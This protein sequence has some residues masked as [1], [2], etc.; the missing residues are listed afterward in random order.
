MSL[1]ECPRCGR[2]VATNDTSAGAFELPPTLHC[3]HDGE[4]VEMELVSEAE[5]REEAIVNE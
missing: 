3:V 5:L 2:E 1:H 4:A